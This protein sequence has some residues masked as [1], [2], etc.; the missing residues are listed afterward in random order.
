MF[1]AHE[2]I[3]PKW[4]MEKTNVDFVSLFLQWQNRI[5]FIKLMIK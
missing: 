3:P 1:N 4:V 2:T 5:V